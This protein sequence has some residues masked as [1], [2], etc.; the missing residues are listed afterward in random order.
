MNDLNNRENRIIET[1]NSI[2]EDM[3][4]FVCRLV[5]DNFVDAL[6]FFIA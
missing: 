2:T 5:A 4:D 6:F 1:V 3:V